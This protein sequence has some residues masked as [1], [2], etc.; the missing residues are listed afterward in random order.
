LERA[1]QD[2]LEQYGFCQV[3]VI[4][5]QMALLAAGEPDFAAI[6]NHF[7]PA[8]IPPRGRPGAAL[9]H[10]PG[11]PAVTHYPRLGISLGI[12][13]WDGVVAIE[14]HPDVESVYAG[15]AVGIVRPVRIRSAALREKLTWG[16]RELQIDRLWAQG[17]TGKG[18][19][20]GHLD[21]G[22]DESH[23][24]LRGRVAGFAE[25]DLLGRRV[26]GAQPHDSDQHGTHTAG[27][28]A[29]RA[30]GRRAIG[31]APE[32]E[33]YSGLVIEGGQ[34]LA[35]VLGGMEWL[36]DNGIKVLSMSL[37][38][39]GYDPSFLVITRRLRQLGMLPVFAIGNEGIGTSRSPGNYPETLS[40]GAVDEQ[41][42]VPP[43]SASVRFNRD[44]DPN[45]PD[46][47][48]PGVGIISA[49]PG[50]G[51]QSLDG[52][53]MATP[54]VAG[55][56]ALLWQAKPDATVDQIELAIR[57]TARKLDG[58]D[59]HRCGDGLVDPLAALS[60]LTGGS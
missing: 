21:T 9:P 1:L 3:I 58:E 51:Y 10:G 39:R 19:R 11:A 47:V 37:G 40:V 38:W 55:V 30:V 41:L 35:R 57:Q 8:P 23:P 56:A 12:A 18:V 31:V 22:V 2:Q 53:S 36:L 26:E 20:V 16:L 46:V 4:H 5:R 45:Q 60:A 17:L 34:V 7:L 6:D 52:T 54:H 27:T 59:P 13:D 50:G 25:W 24:A 28:L 44:R 42:R 48:A 14:S 49:K 43:F 15:N 29:G 33:L 32:C